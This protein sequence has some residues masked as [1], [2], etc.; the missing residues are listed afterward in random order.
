MLLIL[1]LSGLWAEPQSVLIILSCRTRQRHLGVT[2]TLPPNPLCHNGGAPL[3][4]SFVMQRTIFSFQR[5]ANLVACLTRGERGAE[6][7]LGG[8]L[9]RIC[10]N[11]KCI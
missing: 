9:A 5:L 8:Q 4:F 3:F 2:E 1:T 11:E 10:Y 7:T 6:S